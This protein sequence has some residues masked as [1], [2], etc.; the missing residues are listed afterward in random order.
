MSNDAQLGD[1]VEI[2]PGC[3]I[4]GP[5]VIGTGTRLIAQVYLHG[6]VRIG[7]ENTLYPSVQIG[8]R[9]QS[10][11]WDESMPG[12]GVSIGDRNIL[13]EGVTIHHASTDEHPTQLG[14]DN[15]LMTNSHIGHDSVVGNNVTLA[16]GAL[17]AGHAAIL[18][19][20]NMG[21]N[22]A[23]HQFCRMGRYSMIQGGT[24]SARDVPPFCIAARQITRVASVNLVALRRLGLPHEAIDAVRWAFRVYYREARGVPQALA[25]IDERAAAGGPGADLLEEF[26]SFIRTTKQ[27]IAPGLRDQH[28]EDD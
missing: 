10:R 9:P 24:A 14:D 22:A 5:S 3:I 13:R 26:A 21:G 6:E 2:G 1:D 15:Y 20:V 7:R 25:A 18:D 16:S 23:L 28:D 8:F 12:A 27:G 4:D 17:V 19:G 11:R